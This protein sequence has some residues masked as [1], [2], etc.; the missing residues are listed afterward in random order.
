MIT[1]VPRAMVT[2]AWVTA[3]PSN[4]RP[5]APARPTK[6]AVIAESCTSRSGCVRSD[7]ATRTPSE[8][9]TAARRTPGTPSAKS[10]RSRSGSCG[11]GA[12]SRASPSAILSRLLRAA[13]HLGRRPRPARAALEA[14]HL[15][16]R[17]LRQLGRRGLRGL[18]VNRCA[19]NLAGL[20]NPLRQPGGGRA[21]RRDPGHG[22]TAAVAP[23]CGWP[24][25][26]SRRLASL[27]LAGPERGPA[28]GIVVA[29][30]DGLEDGRPV[31]RIR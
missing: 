27:L 14:C 10:A 28:E 16:P 23:G 9:T 20:R 6:P 26:L 30:P 24:G 18:L 12:G 8:A 13:V 21:C 15:A 22:T 11:S 29:G 3:P 17:D 1:S 2:R 5:A 25:G 4:I 7:T 19:A 31:A